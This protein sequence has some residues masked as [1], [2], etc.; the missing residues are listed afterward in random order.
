[1]DPYGDEIAEWGPWWITALT[2]CNEV[3]VYETDDDGII[4]M[5]PL[6]EG[7]DWSR[8][9]NG[10]VLAIIRTSGID[11]DGHYHEAYAEMKISNVPNNFIKSG[12]LTENTTWRGC[13]IITG[14]LVVLP[15]IS[16]TIYPNSNITFQNNASL[17]VNGTLNATDCVL[18]GGMDTW[19][20][21]TFDGSSA[22]SSVLDNVTLTLNR[23]RTVRFMLN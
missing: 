20:S 16:L 5:S 17:I 2:S 21:I 4:Y 15:G 14:N 23:I 3:L 22:S 12:T 10:Y 1:M 8:D 11:T 9:E 13:V 18:S 6:P 19:G 7:Y